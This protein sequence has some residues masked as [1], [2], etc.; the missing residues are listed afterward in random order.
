MGIFDKLLDAMRLTEGED[1]NPDDSGFEDDGDFEDDEPDITDMSSY[2]RS[3]KSAKNRSSTS[4][5][6][7]SIHNSGKITQ[8]RSKK[9]EADG[10]EIC[11]I[12]PKSVDDAR[13]ITDTLLSNRPV[14]L[15]VEGL[16]ISIAQRI[17]DFAAGSC[18]AINGNLQKI[19]NFI[20]VISPSTVDISG[21]FL[22]NFVDEDSP[23]HVNGLH[24]ES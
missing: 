22:D 5:K 21:D 11:V 13:E 19:T 6:E 8:I 17:I 9:I 20:I 4:K 18:Y 2:R 23:F 3:D 15:N 7:K 10:M 14:L 12:K 24:A 16:D 1:E